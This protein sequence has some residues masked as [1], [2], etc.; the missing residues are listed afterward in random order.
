MGGKRVKQ[1]S[2]VL[3]LV[4]LLVPW[5][6]PSNTNADIRH[7]TISLLGRNYAR[8]SMNERIFYVT[9][10]V[11]GMT[12]TRPIE[13][14]DDMVP[15]LHECIAKKKP[16]QLDVIVAGYISKHPELNGAGLDVVTFL[17]FQKSCRKSRK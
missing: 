10:V 4:A 6:Y 7:L 17:A 14:G 3:I 5:F 8:M 13:E 16:Y 12:L 15:W 1:I 11:H 9:G 2:I